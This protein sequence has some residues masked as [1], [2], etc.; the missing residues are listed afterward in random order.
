LR[1]WFWRAAMSAAGPAMNLLCLIAIGL[2]L[3]TTGAAGDLDPDPL[4]AALGLLAFLQATALI[5]NLLPIPGLDGFGILQAV[6]PMGTRAF[7]ARMAAPLMIAFLV[8]L[9]MSPQLLAPL[10]RAAFALCSFFWVGV[11]PI[12]AGIDLFRFWEA[13]ADPFGGG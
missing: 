9:F 8:V 1:S 7:V 11:K 3:R 12:A 4:T 5:L 13:P 6:L 10:W 2:T